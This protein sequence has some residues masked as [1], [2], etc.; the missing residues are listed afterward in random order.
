MV[1]GIP[2]PDRSFVW[3]PEGRPH[4]PERTEHI[5]TTQ[6]IGTSNAGGSDSDPDFRPGFAGLGV[7]NDLADALERA[8]INE[9]WPIQ[10]LTIPD[11]IAGRDVCGKAKTGS[12]KTLAFGIPLL[13]RT[14]RAVSRR[15]RALILVPT[16]ELAVQVESV[17]EPLA[18]VRRL[19]TLSVYGGVGF[20]RQRQLLERGVEIVIATP[21]RMND[22]LNQRELT[23][24]DVDFVVIDEADHMADI[25]F[26][27]Q[28]A[29]ILDQ[30]GH[31]AQTLLFS[32]TLDGAVGALIRRYQKDPVHHAVASA[33]EMVEMMEHRF[34]QVTEDDKLKVAV[35]ICTG[36]A[37]TLVFVRTQRL[38]D[39]VAHFMHREGLKTQA[40]HGGLGQVQR[41]RALGAFADGKIAVLVATNVAARGLDIDGVDTVLHYDPPED[42][43]TYLHRSGRTARAGEAGMVVTL[44]LPHQ[45]MEVRD[46]R[47][48]D[49]VR[50]QIV[51]VHS[52]D[53]RLLDLKS[54][55]PP[56]EEAP[57]PPK[58]QSRYI[59]SADSLRRDGPP[60]I[61]A[62]RPPSPRGWR[63]RR[64]R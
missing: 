5:L 16:R 14:Q 6:T 18:A 29:A 51:A 41:Q 39:R 43:K 27:P 50:Q 38:A 62:I 31:K 9:P 30:L 47:R 26:L 40:I 24:V 34:I 15:P 64:R 21:G 22:L 36:S 1:Q 8:G 63:P 13:Q 42:T 7:D 17:L 46:M 3:L 28:V 59:L 53:P 33:T 10:E 20:G 48:Q 4:T 25:G 37:R 49:G 45:V 19:R 58:A 23:L 12:G 44:V 57:P 55:E 61:S 56:R 52:G 35:D 54:W 60:V 2:S 32:A 11:A